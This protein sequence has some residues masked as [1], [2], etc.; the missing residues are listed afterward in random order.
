VKVTGKLHL[1]NGSGTYQND[2]FAIF[3]FSEQ[4]KILEWIDYNNPNTAAKT[5]GLMSKIK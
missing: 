5:F 4:A 3:I 2:Y 1:K